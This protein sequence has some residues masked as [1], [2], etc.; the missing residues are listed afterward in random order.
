[1]KLFKTKNYILRIF[2]LLICIVLLNNLVNAKQVHSKANS[3]ID[4]SDIVAVV[5]NK[6]ITG[7]DFIKSYS[8]GP[9]I[10]KKAGSAKSDYLNAMINEELLS[11]KLL[12]CRLEGKET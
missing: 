4:S 11:H 9:P 2:T 7:E 6:I 10:L 5:G 3:S 12:L 8:F 1:M